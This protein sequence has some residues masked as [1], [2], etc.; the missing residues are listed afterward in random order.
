MT[1]GTVAYNAALG[2]SDS[3]VITAAADTLLSGIVAINGTGSSAA[4]NLSVHRGSGQTETLAS[5]LNVPA[6]SAIRPVDMAKMALGAVLLRIG[7]TLH[8]SASAATTVTL[9]AFE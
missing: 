2:T 7:D 1:V 6:D 3:A 8:A 9:L 4:L 5:A